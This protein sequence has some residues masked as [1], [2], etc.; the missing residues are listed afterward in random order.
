MSNFPDTQRLYSDIKTLKRRKVQNM[1]TE[2]KEVVREVDIFVTG[3]VCK[4]V[5]GCWFHI[6]SICNPGEDYLVDNF[7]SITWVLVSHNFY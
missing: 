6:F 5:A 1:V 4:S 7:V 2:S 3:F